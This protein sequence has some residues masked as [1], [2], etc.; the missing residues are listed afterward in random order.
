MAKAVITHAADPA[1]IQTQARQAGRDVQLSPRHAFDK[2]LHRTQVARFGGDKHRHGF[3]DSDHIQRLVHG[4]L[5]TQQ[6]YVMTGD[7]G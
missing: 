4:L 3:A 5:L 7:G 1:D 6:V 2:V